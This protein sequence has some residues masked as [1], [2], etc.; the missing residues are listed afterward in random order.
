MEVEPG[1]S[2]NSTFTFEDRPLPPG[3]LA[4]IRRVK[5]ISPGSFHTFGTPLL[6]G[7]D[8]SW[9]D[10]FEKRDVVIIS[11][12]IANQ[13]WGSP[14]AA[15]GKRLRD[16]TAGTWNEIVG[17]S[18]DVYDNGAHLPPAAIVYWPGRTK[19]NYWVR[20]RSVAFAMRTSRA[21][22]EAL[23]NEIRTAVRATD[24]ELPVARV[25]TLSALYDRSMARTWFTLVML[26]M[27]GGI[28]LIIGVIGLYGVVAY[29]VAQ[30]RREVGIRM[31][32]GAEAGAIRKMFLFYGVTFTGAGIV[33]GLTAA[34]ALSRVLSSLLYSV[35]PLDPVTYVAA[36]VA[37]LL[38]ALAA[39]YIPARRAATVDPVETLRME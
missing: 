10:L 39:C 30:R 26:A 20:A 7:R 19:A 18:G 34:A 22:T 33:V 16:G 31:A 4:P 37:L 35:T 36:R 8:L 14:G 29:T 1:I 23:M 24:P 27:A 3:Q 21:G 32:L 13:L 38:A 17:V 6:A 9:P 2:T 15:I 12:S 11:A 25:Q 28:A 5:F